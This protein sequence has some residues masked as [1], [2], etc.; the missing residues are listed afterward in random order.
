MPHISRRRF[1]HFEQVESQG[2]QARFSC[3]R[4]HR[5]ELNIPYR[6]CRGRTQTVSVI[7]KNPSSANEQ[8][9][10]RTIQIVETEVFRLFA[11]AARL[12]VLNLFAMC[13]TDTADLR[14]AIEHC[15]IAW[16][17][18]HEND[19]TLRD[20]IQDSDHVVA[21]WGTKSKLRSAQYDARV[22]QV[23]GLLH[24]ARDKLWYVGGL[25]TKATHPR[26]GMKWRSNDATRRFRTDWR[27]Y[28]PA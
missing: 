16:A 6:P 14:R 9:A 17:I 19:G 28:G 20:A 23:V 2:I 22:S 18:G 7:L 21:A 4:S 25:S 12:R 24:D 5:W 11:A 8:F 13:A 15:G 10:D 1:R 3:G 26:H 27:W